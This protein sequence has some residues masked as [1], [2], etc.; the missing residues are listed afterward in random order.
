MALAGP[1]ANLALVVIAALAI[2]GGMLLGVFDAPD[3][4]EFVRVTEAL[5]PGLASAVA[6]LLSISFSL[7]LILLVFNLLPLPPLDGSQVVVLFLDESY[8]E[9]YSRIIHQPALRIIGLIIAWHVVGF[10]LGPVHV[11]AINILYFPGHSYYQL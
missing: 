5:S 1:I 10:V 11:L 8:A 2:R 7:N 3:K 9:R 6:T 4:T